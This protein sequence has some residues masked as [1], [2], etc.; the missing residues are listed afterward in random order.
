MHASHKET[1]RNSVAYRPCCTEK[2]VH[3]YNFNFTVSLGRK[4]WEGGQSPFITT[5]C[6]VQLPE[7]AKN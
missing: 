3:V 1:N 2:A 5:V 7:Q 6:S 4:G